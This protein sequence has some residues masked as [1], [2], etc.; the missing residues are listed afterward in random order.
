MGEIFNQEIEKA[1]SLSYNR[2]RQARVL[3]DLGTAYLSTD[4]E[5]L[6]KS[7]LSVKTARKYLSSQGY[8]QAEIDDF[9]L[10]KSLLLA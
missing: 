3:D 7:L 8:T 6:D 1:K 4:F 9:F 10:Q 2:T 5:G